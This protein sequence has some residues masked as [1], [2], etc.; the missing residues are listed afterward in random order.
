MKK[1]AQITPL[2]RRLEARSNTPYLPEVPLIFANKLNKVKKTPEEKVENIMRGYEQ[3]IYQDAFYTQMSPEILAT[4]KAQNREMEKNKLLGKFS[5]ANPKIPFSFQRENLSR[6]SEQN[7]KRR[8]EENRRQKV[9]KGYL[10]QNYEPLEPTRAEV[11]RKE[12]QR[13]IKPPGSLLMEEGL[14]SSR[15]IYKKDPKT[16]VG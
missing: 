4:T 16:D 3:G 2:E 15:N 13:M 5:P 9:I 10:A 1:N 12:L 14:K 11:V 7:I 8:Q 6:K